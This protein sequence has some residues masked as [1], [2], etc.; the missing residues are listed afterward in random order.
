MAWKGI[1]WQKQYCGTSIFP[2]QR[3]VV[4]LQKG[5]YKGVKVHTKLF[6]K[7]KDTLVDE[8]Y[9][10]PWPNWGWVKKLV[11]KY[12]QL[13]VEKVW[14]EDL[15]VEVCHGG[16]PGIPESYWKYK[17]NGPISENL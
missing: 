8:T 16:W 10:T 9:Y 6:A 3:N 13:E 5:R 7:Q 4:H 17:E 12:T 15:D 2:A 11:E 14:Q 1:D